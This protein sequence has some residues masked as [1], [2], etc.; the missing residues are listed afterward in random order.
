MAQKSAAPFRWKWALLAIPALLALQIGGVTLLVLLGELGPV[1][2]VLV[3]AA[4]YF[5]GFLIAY[6]SPGVT[7]RE[8]AVGIMVAVILG[9]LLLRESGGS[10]LA[11]L[12]ALVLGMAGA[13]VGEFL[14]ARR[15]A[16]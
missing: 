10:V 11:G 16:T 7:V 3:S 2:L 4:S 1:Q 8:P 6:W 9:S 14:Q 13:K 15:R 12:I 5:R